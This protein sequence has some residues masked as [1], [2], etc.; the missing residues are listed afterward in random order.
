MSKT[1][2]AAFLPT[3]ALSFCLIAF[4]AF[5]DD[6]RTLYQKGREEQVESSMLAAIELYRASLRANPDYDQP[7]IGLAEC[8]FALEESLAT[9]GQDSHRLEPAGPGASPVPESYNEGEE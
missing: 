1:G 6:A 4:K 9:G 2:R 5:P 8:F 3:I 7:M